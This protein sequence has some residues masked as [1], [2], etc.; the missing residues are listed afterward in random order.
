[1]HRSSPDAAFSFLEIMAAAGIVAIFLVGAF[2][3]NSRGLYMIRCAKET[4]GAGKILQQRMEQLRAADWPEV[5]DAATVQSYYA[6]APDAIA[7]CNQLTETV[8]LVPWPVVAGAIAMKITRSATGTVTLVSDN[9]AL[10]DGAGVLVTTRVSWTGAGNRTR[11]R[12]TCT[13]IANGGLGR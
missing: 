10:V 13:V 6:T 7:N 5:T 8:T 11:V 12:E 4:A 3:A 9:T 2:T 1:M